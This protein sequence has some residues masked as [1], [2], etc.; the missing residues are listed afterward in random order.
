MQTSTATHTKGVIRTLG[1]IN[2]AIAAVGLLQLAVNVVG[3]LTLG[4]EFMDKYGPFMRAQHRFAVMSIVTIL[5]LPPLGLL[6]I[7]LLRGKWNV[8]G[9]CKI[10]FVLEIVSFFVILLKWNLPFFPISPVVIIP[11]LMNSGLA[12]QIA[13][14]YPLIGFV[15]LVRESGRI[16]RQA[17]W[18][19]R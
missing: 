10:F 1:A 6:G 18:P 19:A 4:G 2:V 3:Y 13:T 9:I 15:L 14:A 11:G 16:K 17:G 8:L 12:L 5:L 7:L